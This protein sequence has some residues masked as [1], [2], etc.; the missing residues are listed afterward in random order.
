MKKL[1][2]I[3]SLAI[4][5]LMTGCDLWEHTEPLAPD[6]WGAVPELLVE[7]DSAALDAEGNLIKDVLP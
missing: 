3:F 7:V 2:Y 1:V 5:L 4:G 6:T